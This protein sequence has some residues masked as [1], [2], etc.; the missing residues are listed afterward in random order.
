M[1][2]ESDTDFKDAAYH[3]EWS[4][5]LDGMLVLS[6]RIM[7]VCFD[8][9]FCSSATAYVLENIR[10]RINTICTSLKAII[11]IFWR[12]LCETGKRF[13]GYCVFKFW[14]IWRS[15]C[16]CHS[17]AVFN[18]GFL[19]RTRLPGGTGLT[20]N[21]TSLQVFKSANKFL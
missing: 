8:C 6:M 11:F 2:A 13:S 5:K 15:R 3:W 12:C 19:T 17:L 21:R 18:M 1:S 10:N 4:L 14:W 16:F 9:W 7:K 20:S